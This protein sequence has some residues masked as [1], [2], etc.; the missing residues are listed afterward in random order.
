[1]W[2]LDPGKEVLNVLFNRILAPY[3][4]N[5]DMN[6]VN[7]GIGQGQLT[8]HK[9][10]LKKGA[11]DNFR[12]PVDVT[13]GHLG[14]F[15]LS[16][17]WMNLGNQPV[18]I[19]IEDVYLL[20]TP[21]P[22]GEEDPEDEANRVHA[23]KME[24]LENAELLHMRSQPEAAT[25]DSQKSQGL[26][27]SLIT[28]IV[29]NLQVTIKNV[30]IRYEDKLSVPGHPFAAGIT[31]AGFTAISTDENW[32][33]AFIDST[34]GAVHKLASL[35]SLAVYFDTDSASMA[36]LPYT[37]AVQKFNGLISKD[38]N[39]S[40]HQFILKPVTG[41]GRI[42]MHSTISKDV[43]KFDIELLFDEIGVLLDD[44]Q[45][46][47]A[48]SLVDMYHFYTRQHQYRKYR[49]TVEAL[50]SNRPLALLQF[51]GRA[52]LAEVKERRY[53]W[54]W[55]Y[56][57]TRRDDRK[58][59]V[60][61]F[62]KKL[63]ENA[64]PED[65]VKLDELERR[66]DY[67]D[68][69]F[70]RSI[71]RQ[72]AR[73][74]LSEKRRD[75]KNKKPQTGGWTGWLW[76][77]RQN[78]SDT[79]AA[80]D[81]FT[82]GEMNDEQRRQ[83]Y[84]VLDYDE[85]TALA[86]SFSAPEDALKLRVTSK[87]NKGSFGLRTDPHGESKDIVSVVFD[88]FR[89]NFTQRP[90][91]FDV[92][93]SLGGFE[94]YDGTAKN[95]L[96][97][98]IVHVKELNGSSTTVT[99]QDMLRKGSADAE[100]PFFY[101][102]F[103]KAPVDE[104]ADTALTMRMRHMEI[105]YHRGIVEAV[106][107]FFRPPASQLE[108]VE[109]LLDVASQTLEGLRKE[110]R[111]G[112]EY[113]LQKHKT[114]DVQMDLN[115]PIIIIPEDIT[116]TTGKHLLIDAGHIAIESNLAD[117]ELIR[118]IHLKRS[119]KYSEEDYRR[120]ES[121]MY[122]KFFLR[123]ESAQFVIGDDI[124]ACRK[125]L[126][127]SE[128]DTLHLLERINM[129]FEVQNSIVPT[130]YNLARFKVSGN[131]PTLQLNM[132][133]IKYRSLMR[134]IDVSIPH[135]GDGA[136]KKP[137]I[138]EAP[139]SDFPLSPLPPTF[140]LPGVFRAKE[141]AYTVEDQASIVENQKEEAENNNEELFEAS[142]GD[143]DSP[144]IHQHT[145]ELNFQVQKLRAA[146]FRSTGNGTERPLGDVTF[147]RFS[148]AFAL[149]KY[150]MSVDIDLRSVSMNICQ[151]GFQAI[152][153]MSSADTAGQD[154]LLIVRYRRCQPE[155]PVFF[156]QFD[157]IDQSVDIK[158][159]TFI[160]RAAPEPVL[161]VYDFIMT[162]FV[163]GPTPNQRQQYVAPVADGEVLMGQG[164]DPAPVV[165]V[166]Q[167]AIQKIKVL[168]NLASVQVILMNNGVKLSTLSLSIANV[169]VLLSNNTMLVIGRLGSLNLVDDSETY[170]IHP[171]FEQIL[172]IEGDNFAEFSYQ[173]FDPT[174]HETYAGVK[175]KVHLAAGSIK[176]NF[177]EEPLH[178]IYLFLAKLARL[179]GVYDAATQAAVQRAQEIERM[180]FG[181]SVKT[182]IIIFPSD[183]AHSPDRLTLRLGELSASNSFDG[184]SS[185][186]T[187]GLTGIQLTSDF[188]VVDGPSVLKII[189]DINIFAEIEQ[190]ASIDRSVDFNRPDS[191]IMI[192]ISDVK[193]H[194]TQSQYKVL[195][196]LSR[197]IPRILQGAPQ[198]EHQADQSL[199]IKSPSI[200]SPDSETFPTKVSA[201]LQPELAVP[202]VINGATPWSTVDLAVTI[203]VV[204]LHLYDEHATER[205]L[206]DCGIAR[207]ALNNN[208]LR[209]KVLS[210]G[211]YEAQ[212]I[213]KSFTMSNTRKG[214]TKFREIIPAARHD[215]NQVMILYSAA[216]GQD[217]SSVAIVTVDSPQLILAIDPM[218]ALLDFAMSPFN[219]SPSQPQSGVASI[220]QA[221]TGSAQAVT[222]VSDASEQEGGVGFR[223]DLHDVVVSV[224]EDETS[225]DS[226]AIRLYVR[227]LLLS[228]QGI[229]ALT[230]E[231]LGMSLARMN[232]ISDSARFLDNVDLTFSLD[233]RSTTSQQLT[234]IEIGAKPIV[235]RAS[236]HDINLITNIINKAL[237]MYGNTANSR[238]QKP[239][240][241][242]KPTADS[243]TMKSSGLV[244][245]R[246]TY[247]PIAS[248]HVITSK[249][250]LKATFEGLSIVLIGDVHEQPM[251]HLKIKPFNV[252]VRD[253]S[254]D[255]HATTTLA[256]HISYWNLTNSHWE[257]STFTHSYQVSRDKDTGGTHLIIFA[258]ERLD[259]NISTTLI[260]LA[261]SM[262]SH[263]SKGKD[264]VLALAR[265][266]YAPYR[267]RNR[268]GSP[269]NIWGDVE[270][271]NIQEVVPTRIQNNETIDWRFDDW[272]TM[273][274]HVTSAGNYSI[275]VQ[276]IE[277]SWEQLRSVPVDREGEFC[278]ALRP[279][280][281]NSPH[282]LLCEVK[283]QDNVKLV[284]LRS[285]YKIENLT[286]YPIELT[287][288]DDKGRPVY[289]LE[290]IAPGQ[291][292]ALP[293]EAVGHNRVRIQPDQGFGYKWSSAIRYE[294]L[295]QRKT[296]TVKCPHSDE[297][298]SAF[299]F[300]VYV[301]VDANDITL[302]R[303][304]PKLS[305]RL[306][307][308]IELENLLP[309]DIQYR[310]YD[311]NTDQQW[312]SYLRHGGIMPV[313]SVE[314][315][316]V[317]LLNITIQDTV[318][319]PSDFAIINTDGHSDFEV[320]SQ[321]QIGDKKDG[322]LQLKLNYV[323]YPDSGGAFKVQIYS[324][325]VVVNKT[326]L[327]FYI[328]STRSN[329]PGGGQDVPG[330]TNPNV[331]ATPTPYLASHPQDGKEF[332]FK[333]EGSTW[334]KV[335]SLEAPSAD[336]N[337]SIA[338]SLQKM[339][340]IHV[341]LSWTEALG[342]YK[343]TKVITLNPRFILINR[344]NTDITFREHGGAARG[345]IAPGEKSFMHFMRTSDE[346]LLTLAHPG[347]N[348]RWSPAINMED[349]GPIHV[350]LP[351]SEHASTLVRVDI[352][353]D[354]STFF[355]YLHDAGDHWPFKI[356]NESD[357]VVDFSQ[358]DSAHSETN[359]VGHR[360]ANP[361][362]TLVPKSAIDYAW[363]YPAAREK[364]ILLMI[365]GWRRPVDILEIGNLMPFRF[366]DR[367]G[368]RAVSLDVRADG[369]TQ[370]LQ[371]TNYNQASSVY[372][373]RHRASISITR[374]DTHVSS[375]DA[376]EAV[377]EEV[378][379]TLMFTLDLEGI[380]LSLMNRKMLEVIY[381]SMNSLKFEYSSSPVAQA[382][383]LSL[384]V[385]QIDNQLHDAI[386][387]VL[388]QPT[389]IPREASVVASP[390]TIQA[391]VI[392]LNDQAHGVLFIKYC[393]VLLQ[394]LTI[395]TDED[396]L[397]SLYDLTKIQGASWNAQALDVLI[398]HPNDIPE[399]KETAPGQHL[400]FE[401]LELQPIRLQLSFMR[402]E[403]ISAEEKLNLRN[404]L[405]VFLNAVTMAIGNVNDAPLEMNSLAIKDMRLTTPDLQAR[406][407]YH[408]KQEVLRQLYRIIGSAD[409]IGNPVGLFTNVS[410]GVAD[411][412]YE[413][414]N[415]VV[416]HGNRE[417]GIG[418]AKGAASFVKKTVFGFS[419]SFT[420]FTS[421]VG[422]GLSAAT[423]DEEYQNRR[424]MTQRRNKP[425]H[426]IY[427]VTSGAEAFATSIASGFEGV[428]MKP[429]EGAEAGGAVGFFKGVGKGLVGAVTKPVVGVFD[430]ASNVSEGIRNTTTVFDA[431]A[432]ERI[433]L[434]RH[435]PA[436]G[437]LVPY[438]AR[439]ANGQ[440]LT[441][442]LSDGAYRNEFYVAHINVPGGDNIVLLTATRVVSFWS[443]KLTLEWDLPFTH[444]QGVTIEDTGIRFAHKAGREHD[445]F[446]YVPDKSSQ[447]WFFGQIATVVKS[448]NA[449]KRM[450]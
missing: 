167:Q 335:V 42:V 166:E 373:P 442:E 438:D 196:G 109:A 133:D 159:S 50:E 382:V 51:A 308:P 128:R 119:Q 4:V 310:I 198:G 251:L 67:D 260:E 16:L 330:E 217:N 291:D 219:T 243:A 27:A 270:G 25:E 288:V 248:A 52:I 108:S 355:I 406:I 130:A 389:P 205:N 150:D 254:G 407:I 57:A 137:Q 274:E 380:G 449:K 68:V 123:L 1:M 323:R 294:D 18:E 59:Y 53:R 343:L 413:P 22:Q 236:Y 224:L 358:M 157:G 275:S 90:E 62:R 73:K 47:D 93:I 353:I 317:V 85:R 313:H 41:D 281:D 147:E 145:F 28:K 124:Q 8:L 381:L 259:I 429:I 246:A 392:W 284:T 46:R 430:L 398:E 316:H 341:G 188:K 249:E 339:E 256:T 253:W 87:L 116:T 419:D 390:P 296:F 65:T 385:L 101:L 366:G 158:V 399:P 11:L 433:R 74:E 279:R 233:S 35:Q 96:Y 127:S 299:R 361:S 98:Q 44:N 289:S 421:S 439:A 272:K 396:F 322:K 336:A 427:G 114:L 414:F 129:D 287:L 297:H 63:L 142:N 77:S 403:R 225:I 267:I 113:A 395:E 86:E 80:D 440:Y 415:G 164:K 321:L 235:F 271:V 21:S 332:L 375:Q 107:E 280:S 240:S 206:R 325:Y 369:Q 151:P 425:R 383:N 194:L 232:N 202:F 208:S 300:H 348:A 244:I 412:F 36:G 450:D 132:S 183:S 397:L 443:R 33:P 311:K 329:R 226:R 70:Y 354:A 262:F 293:I 3:V 199:S 178:D 14:K 185:T 115:A 23:A 203:G 149:A 426:A 121:L 295:L 83:L 197:A 181:V 405:A 234:S 242:A 144:K 170:T 214:D 173:T 135:F 106:Y 177:L 26:I 239:E 19:L 153:F 277:Q 171:Q 285:A 193:L 175:S 384:G 152:E 210:N 377:T 30:H 64:A 290:K 258:R 402:T 191:Q 165:V 163:P 245:T 362:Y 376:F 215:R 146:L 195:I 230:I 364:K 34:A 238:T 327:P 374:Q 92:S 55:K 189:D 71:A 211:S 88:I 78:A 349:I 261:L 54:T 305:L 168:V 110:T 228:Q 379:P 292:Y 319:Q 283:V 324:P 432:R 334:S 186:I 266:S 404:P 372:R 302:R 265:G 273:R 346:K 371:I 160:F 441:K 448:F 72:R 131:L 134:L 356:E 79:K 252:N 446:V 218:F 424:R 148:L 340:E 140:T 209:M 13:E 182:P 229:L 307:A 391:S 212:V 282:R 428:I 37:E 156:T 447:N 66:L 303:K 401:V 411:I 84:E 344:L 247:H 126:T 357:Y 43:P 61:R 359:P 268:T 174:D 276:F 363:D 250:Q 365:N 94:V 58:E 298:E 418:I 286:L 138:P 76:G 15:T 436:D 345:S 223:F 2:W 39:S 386:Y 120:L 20:V 227:Q 75:E 306:R 105:I 416:V 89:A 10:R 315:A 320:E 231:D 342:K 408:Y 201:S 56:F 204:K 352:K 360:K 301:Q 445:K 370:I 257:P 143:T 241:G 82:T 49:P 45:Y 388:L 423:L 184:P 263:W 176:I 179:K 417:L 431:P 278:F 192:S 410:S 326:G 337:L 378:P 136:P 12:L 111:A 435:T 420:K 314:L 222:Q 347:L 99:N 400:Y 24:R 32:K 207:F 387:P 437:V 394:A 7:Y 155:S 434:P 213:L 309:Y 304:P 187:A 5:L 367:S 112:L 97:P 190:T 409:F 103:E 81:P 422:K 118:E 269:I 169:S 102:K 221:K 172:S 264:E 331:L 318:Y 350:H 200:L 104:R 255:L 6:Q 154:D 216:G 444:V 162:T 17:H 180:Q 40:D 117:K 237:E 125:A 100:D 161:A 312:K 141:T 368:T 338:S 351:S 9:L 95:S 31:L 29:N 69:R 333:I 60:E 328:K 139:K 220:A 122:D 38:A 48:I 91:G 393:S